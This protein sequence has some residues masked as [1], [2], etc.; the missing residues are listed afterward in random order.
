MQRGTLD[1]T[2]HLR[3]QWQQSPAGSTALQELS[4]LQN[5]QRQIEEAIGGS[6]GAT[7]EL[8]AIQEE[9]VINRTAEQRLGLK[10]AGMLDQLEGLNEQALPA[11]DLQLAEALQSG[12]QEIEPAAEPGIALT[13]QSPP[14]ALAAASHEQSKVV[15]VLESI[16]G[17][18]AEL[19][20]LSRI[21]TQLRQIWH[22]QADLIN[23]TREQQQA[24]LA[25]PGELSADAKA[26][27]RQLGEFQT[28]LAL[29][30]DKLQ[31]RL[32]ALAESR[33]QSESQAPLPAAARA[34]QRLAIG[35]QMRFAAEQLLRREWGQALATETAVAEALQQLQQA[36][37]PA[38][39][40]DQ[41]QQD[42]PAALASGIAALAARQ[43][44]ALSAMEEMHSAGDF[45]RP[46][47]GD[48]RLVAASSKQR[49]LAADT[50][51]LR[52][53]SHP[54]PALDFALSE[55]ADAMQ[56]AGE[57]LTRG[58]LDRAMHDASHAHAR[59]LLLLKALEPVME[60]SAQTAASSAESHASSQNAGLGAELRAV[61]A[62][63]EELNQ[64]THAA[65]SGKSPQSETD[66]LARQQGKLADL[67]Q[68]LLKRLSQQPET[69][70]NRP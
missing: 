25:A 17:E 61:K 10:L 67:T 18:L 56:A 12:R 60:S 26:K 51:Q 69:E 37:T 58:E 65:A 59:L 11:I 1:A 68:D 55:A 44:Q 66:A 50:H 23:E 29:N 2:Q 15:R 8:R 32:E 70:P 19:D 43:Q 45:K 42:W 46:V 28:R 54:A 47:S 57:R 22:E 52:E 21:A 38:G 35:S 63:Q 49:S 4:M 20:N 24:N 5:R 13:G 40:A 48:R 14:V 3:S 27:A 62:M 39:A 53:K 30:L 64:R 6:A 31:L 41:S 34:A 9:M 36:L 7:V 16:V 33:P